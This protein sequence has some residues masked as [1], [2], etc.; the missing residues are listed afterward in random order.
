MGKLTWQDRFWA[1][2]DRSGTQSECWLWT[3]CTTKDGYGR[4]RREGRNC[5]AHR[6]A[7]ELLVGP[8]PERTELDHVRAM[9]C[10]HRNCVNP[11]HLEAVTHHQNVLRGLGPVANRNN[12]CRRG[13]PYDEANTLITSKGDRYCRAC[14]RLRYQAK[15]MLARKPKQPVTHC[16]RGHPFDEVN[17][18][19]I[20]SGP[21]KGKRQCKECHRREARES[22]AR[23]T[24]QV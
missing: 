5:L 8:I 4:F 15:A 12:S 3:A 22:Y 24:Q 14:A 21:R 10:R 1:K 23:K 7:Y 2:V 16:K 9:G 18:M 20:A 6:L 17:T 11:S 13:H 19:V